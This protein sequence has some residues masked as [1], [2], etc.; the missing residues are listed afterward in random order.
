MDE[1]NQ[2]LFN[3]LKIIGPLVFFV[4]IFA[5]I[6]KVARLGLG[7]SALIAGI[8]AVLDYYLL[9]IVMKKAGQ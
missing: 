9:I 2:A 8:I 4:V 1:S 3:K 6:Y 7:L 5:A